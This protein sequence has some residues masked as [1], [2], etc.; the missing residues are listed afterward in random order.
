MAAASN[1]SADAECH[2]ERV[3]EF[4]DPGHYQPGGPVRVV[5][6]FL[7]AVFE[8]Q[9]FD[10]AWTLMD[11]NLR[12]CRVQAWLW[13]N[14]EHPIHLGRDRELLT[15]GLLEQRVDCYWPYFAQ[16]ELAQL[17]ENW[18]DLYRQGLGAASHTRVI[19][20]DLELIITTPV[21]DTTLRIDEPTLLDNALLYIVR[22]TADGWRVAAYCDFLPEPGW[23]PTLRPAE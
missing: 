14:R 13:N 11:D 17:H 15:A 23:P 18:G 19:G 16:I 6:D 22:Y 9:S 7:A 2:D 21:G 12:L 8:Q 3:S 10:A 4:G 1:G 5:W 20:P